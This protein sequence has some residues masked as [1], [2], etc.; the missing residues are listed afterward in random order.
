MQ[1]QPARRSRGLREGV[2]AAAARARAGGRVVA[3]LMVPVLLVST[4]GCTALRNKPTA[5][6]ALLPTEQCRT[7]RVTGQLVPVKVCTLAQQREDIK[8]STQDMQDF[9]TRQVVVPFCD[10]KACN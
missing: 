1:S 5:P 4:S 2:D 10:N 3:W 6:T 9:L 7:Q 8:K